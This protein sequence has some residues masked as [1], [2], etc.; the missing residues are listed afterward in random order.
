[1]LYEIILKKISYN[2]KKKQ[3]WDLYFQKLFIQQK[4]VILFKKTIFF[5]HKQFL[6]KKK[7][8]FEKCLMLINKLLVIYN[9]SSVEFTFFIFYLRVNI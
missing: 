9:S 4:N 2:D 5:Q 1:M 7:K 6:I 8:M 3:G